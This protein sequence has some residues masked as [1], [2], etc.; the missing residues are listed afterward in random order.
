VKVVLDTNVL[1]SGLRDPNGPAGRV[2]ALAIEGPLIPLYDDRIL[3]EYRDVLA[4]PRLR[5]RPEHAAAV[6][7]AITTY[8]IA[9][10]VRGATIGARALD[11]DDQPFLEVALVGEAAAIVTRNRADFPLDAGVSIA[12]PDDVLAWFTADDLRRWLGESS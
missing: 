2:V 1:V 5:I 9:V 6:L 3:A 8:G 11:P 4:R 10:D 7:E 12:W